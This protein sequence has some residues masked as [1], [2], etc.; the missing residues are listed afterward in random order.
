MLAFASPGTQTGVA[1][2]PGNGVL[3]NHGG[4]RVTNTLFCGIAS[5]QVLQQSTGRAFKRDKG[6]PNKLIPQI[7]KGVAVKTVSVIR[8]A[9]RFGERVYL[10]KIGTL[11]FCKSR[12]IEGIEKYYCLQ[13]GGWL[14]RVQQ[15]EQEVPTPV[16]PSSGMVGIDLG[17]AIFELSDGTSYAQLPADRSWPEAT[18]NCRAN[19]TATADNTSEN[20]R[21]DYHA[22]GS[23]TKSAKTK[24]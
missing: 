3:V 19:Q 20:C 18:H 8:K 13:A 10:P 6:Q 14:V 24:L 4:N 23:A 22:H 12:E 1:V 2:V 16:H 17:V 21:H 5:S 15:T 7:L 11:R 9:S